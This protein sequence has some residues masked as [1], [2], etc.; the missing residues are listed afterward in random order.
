MCAGN[1]VH[2]KLRAERATVLLSDS[3]LAELYIVAR[4]CKAVCLCVCIYIHIKIQK[5]LML[6]G[7]IPYGYF[8]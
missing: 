4:L 8:F 2:Y 5:D 3:L 1:Q 7:I 6:V